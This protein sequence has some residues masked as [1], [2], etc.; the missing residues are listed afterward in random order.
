MWGGLHM[1]A[2]TDACEFRIDAVWRMGAQMEGVGETDCGLWSDWFWGRAESVLSEQTFVKCQ[3]RWRGKTQHFTRC[4]EKFG[5]CRVFSDSASLYC[6]LFVEPLVAEGLDNCRL[7]GKIGFHVAICLPPLPP[8][9]L[10]MP[11]GN[12]PPSVISLLCH[13][14]PHSLSPWP[15][16][17]LF[18]FHSVLFGPERTI[19]N[20]GWF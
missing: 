10:W 6:L 15:F 12:I 11:F 13:L 1:K 7:L 3:E 19:L 17:S 2:P 20:K 14:I 18:P 4:E 9:H 16:L 5:F 8:S